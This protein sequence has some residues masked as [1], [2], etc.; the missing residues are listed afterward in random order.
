MNIVIITGGSKGI[1]RALVDH[2]VAQNYKVY[3]LSRSHEKHEKFTQVSV[4]LTDISAAEHIFESVLAE[5]RDLEVSSLSLINNAGRLGD[6]KHLENLKPED[7]SKS[8]QLNV[9]S[10]FLLSSLFIEFG[11]KYSCTKKILNISSGAASSAYAGWSVYC[12]SKAAIDMLTST[13][14]IEQKNKENPVY[15]YGIRPGVVDTEMQ[16]QIRNTDAE[17]F[18]N[19]EKFK[20]LKEN[21][22]LY[23]PEYVAQRIFDILNSDQ[24]K[25]GETI[26]LRE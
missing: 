16:T 4:D 10:A 13:I 25:S 15:S 17:D 8:I 6:I 20:E 14:A 1:G 3:S 7:I 24:M 22:Q 12:A 18:E 9:T 23:K 19:V 26:D 21:D 11:E 5:I 2:Y